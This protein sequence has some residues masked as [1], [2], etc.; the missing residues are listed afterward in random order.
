MKYV[1]DDGGR[2]EA[3]YKGITGDCVVRSIAIASGIPYKKV[4]KD[5]FDVAKEKKVKKASP[6][7]GVGKKVYHDYILKLGFEWVPKMKIGS[8]CTTHLRDG[9]LPKGNLIASCSKH[10]V[11]VID[12]VIHDTYDPSRDGTRCVYGY[13]IKK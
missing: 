6:R 9:E 7:N 3:G 2:S 8:G 12:G 1:Y 10:L 13:Y 4:Y 11:A 5:L